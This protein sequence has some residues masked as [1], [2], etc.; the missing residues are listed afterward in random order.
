MKGSVDVLSEASQ[1]L[2]PLLGYPLSTTAA[3]E[4]F[5]PVRAADS[6]GEAVV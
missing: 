4:E 6:V 2:P 3:S 1:Q 5:K